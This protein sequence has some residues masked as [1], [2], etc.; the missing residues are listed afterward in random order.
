MLRPTGPTPSGRD[1]AP[2]AEFRGD[3]A[4]PGAN[5]VPVPAV[6]GPA[7]KHEPLDESRGARQERP[8]ERLVVD[9]RQ[10]GGDSRDRFRHLKG[11]RNGLSVERSVAEEPQRTRGE[12]GPVT[13]DEPDGLTAPAPRIDGASEDDRIER[14]EAGNL[15]NLGDRGIEPG[16]PQLFGDPI[17]D[18]TGGPVFGR[19]GDQYSLCHARSIALRPP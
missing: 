6:A 17:G 12:L 3:L 4:R 16:F 7:A 15:S 1:L 13:L 9:R 11:G 8:T 10:S 2:R 19:V 18:P 14:L 5:V